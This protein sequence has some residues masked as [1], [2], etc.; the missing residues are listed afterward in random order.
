MLIIESTRHLCRTNVRVMICA[1]KSFLTTTNIWDMNYVRNDVKQ[2]VQ[3][4]ADRG[5]RYLTK[6]SYFSFPS[7]R[8]ANTKYFFWKTKIS[9][10]VT[11]SVYE[12]VKSTK[13]RNG[14]IH[15]IR[16]TKSRMGS[17]MADGIQASVLH[18]PFPIN[19][20]SLNN[21]TQKRHS[22]SWISGERTKYRLSNLLLEVGI[23][24][25]L[26]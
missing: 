26:H 18:V 8:Y 22:G 2:C 17:C 1:G 15:F 21:S 9:T 25:L 11:T 10:C 6:T 14:L 16:H 24:I 13:P 5:K 12:S 4:T 7:R 19:I 20:N 3:Q 23:A